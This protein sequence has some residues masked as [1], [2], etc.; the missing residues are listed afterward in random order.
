M[1][2]QGDRVKVSHRFP[3]SKLDVLGGLKVGDVGSIVWI[4]RS[5]RYAYVP[6]IAIVMWDNGKRTNANEDHLDPA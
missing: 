1:F 2:K 4:M 6:G 3:Q 5:H